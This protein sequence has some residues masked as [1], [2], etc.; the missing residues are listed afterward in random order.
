MRLSFASHGSQSSV[1]SGFFSC[2]SGK[3]IVVALMA[4]DLSSVELP[5]SLH[6]LQT[7]IDET[8]VEDALLWAELSDG[9]SVWVPYQ[10]QLF[11]CTLSD[12]HAVAL[13][14]PCFHKE[15]LKSL[16]ESPVMKLCHETTN[17][18]MSKQGRISSTA[19][20]GS[21]RPHFERSGG[22]SGWGGA[23]GGLLGLLAPAVKAR[24]GCSVCSVPPG[25]G[26]V[27]T[28]DAASFNGLKVFCRDG[29][30]WLI[31][32]GPGSSLQ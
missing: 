16:K 1:I 28:A 10:C 12:D 27:W 19:L 26:L 17:Q 3:I 29:R 11:F 22:H 13:F 5:K 24:G 20:Q 32:L 31:E 25:G 18:Y 7:T 23:L 30:L 4:D 21:P 15:T 6:D 2:L 8:T 9:H 14:T